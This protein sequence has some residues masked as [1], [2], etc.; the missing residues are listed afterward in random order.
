MGLPANTEHVLEMPGNELH[1]RA[2]AGL[3][4]EIRSSAELSGCGTRAGLPPR[5]E[6]HQSKR[7]ISHKPLERRYT[8]LGQTPMPV[9]CFRRALGHRHDYR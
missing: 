3:A 6:N 4:G 5:P 1:R 9:A 7:Q 8:F 2:A